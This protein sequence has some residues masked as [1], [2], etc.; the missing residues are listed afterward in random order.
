MKTAKIEMESQELLA[1]MWAIGVA[2]EPGRR[3]FDPVDEG[4][5]A[6]EAYAIHQRLQAA[7]QEIKQ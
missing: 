2:T 4:E 7:W 3:E 6:D 1:L 5:I